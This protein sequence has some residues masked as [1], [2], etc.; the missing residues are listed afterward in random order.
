[1][2]LLTLADGFGDSVAVPPWYP[3]YFK[4][5]KLIELM[6]KGVELLDYCRYGAGNEYMV[7]QLMHN[8]ASADVVLVQWAAP[9]RLDLVLSHDSD[10]W[11]DVISQDA[12]YSQNIVTCGDNKFW[13]SSASSMDP[14]KL[15]HR[16]YISLK[17]H[18]LRSQVFID[19]A[20]LLLNEHCIPYR[21]MLTV[22]AD[23]LDVNAN[24][25]WHKPYKGMN[26]FRNISQYR[27][28][29]LD[30]VQPIPLILFDFV[31][32]YIMPSVDLNWRKPKEINAVE[33]M[34][35]RHY[36]ESIKNKPYDPN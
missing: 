15:Y 20:K 5:P 13:L 24:W 3:K 7:N 27:D 16:Q 6:T 29:D 18:Q 21:F 19:Y 17:Q 4:W 35:L 25:I 12:V 31:K 30:I 23:Y 34:L 33:N 9:Q 36:R 22:D 28:L 11:D 10:F 14:V 32:Q 26:S 2:K 8:I 1:M